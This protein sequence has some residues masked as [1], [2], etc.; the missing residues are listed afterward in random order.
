MRK[1]ISIL[2]IM[3][4]CVIPVSAWAQ[5]TSVYETGQNN[6]IGIGAH[7]SHV[8]IN[9]SDMKQNGLTVNYAFD[10][11][12]GFGIQMLMS[13]NEF[14]A[15]EL[16]V[17]NMMASD[18]HMKV[19]NQQAKIGEITTIPVTLSTRFYLPT[20]TIVKPYLG[21]GIGYYFNDF[22]KNN[23][24]SMQGGMSLDDAFGFHYCFGADFWIN[25]LE[26]TA[27]N[28]DIKYLKP[29]TQNDHLDWDAWNIGFGIMYYFQ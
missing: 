11:V 16:C 14:L 15:M 4:V 12:L 24:L 3:C 27:L 2:C 17:D 8:R 28:F 18:I 1:T 26:N 22:E 19:N 5:W 7:I 29:D 21:A 6:S 25:R 9:D 23:N 13:F 10:D 20:D